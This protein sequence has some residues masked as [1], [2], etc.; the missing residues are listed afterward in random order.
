[1]R[2][3]AQ[4]TPE[5]APF[6]VHPFSLVP[7][8]E[9]RAE[10]DTRLYAWYYGK[11]YITALP[12]A[13]PIAAPNQLVLHTHDGIPIELS[14]YLINN[15]NFVRLN[16]LAREMVDVFDVVYLGSDYSIIMGSAYTSDGSETL[17]PSGWIVADIRG[18]TILVDGVPYTA[19]SYYIDGLIYYSLRYIFEIIG[20]EITWHEGVTRI[21]PAN[22]IPMP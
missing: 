7:W 14:T 15:N 12:Q 6:S 20:Y 21:F 2:T 11:A 19:L 18:K 17:E 22:G 9:G 13:R 10:L 4:T 8:E 16:D 5:V 3:P 1:M